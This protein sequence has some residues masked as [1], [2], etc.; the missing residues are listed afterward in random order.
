MSA[1]SDN[2]QPE[3]GSISVLRSTMPLPLVYKKGVDV[4]GGYWYFGRAHYL[5]TGG[6]VVAVAVESTQRCEVL[7]RAAGAVRR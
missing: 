1:A 3:S 7:H 5:T 4:I 6:D 2:S